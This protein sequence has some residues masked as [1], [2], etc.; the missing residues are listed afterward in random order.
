MPTMN[1]W[2][3]AGGLG[4]TDNTNWAPDWT[5]IAQQSNIFLL[6]SPS[7]EGISF[8]VVSNHNKA[9]EEK[10]FPTE[11]NPSSS[12]LNRSLNSTEAYSQFQKL[13][14][15]HSG[16]V[17]GAEGADP[18]KSNTFEELDARLMAMSGLPEDLAYE[19]Q[20]VGTTDIGM[21]KV[22]LDL[23]LNKIGKLPIFNMRDDLYLAKM[24]YASYDMQTRINA[25]QSCKV[26][27]LQFY[28]NPEIL[29]AM[30]SANR[31]LRKIY[32]QNRR[33]AL[34]EGK[35]FEEFL[36]EAR[37]NEAQT[38]AP[39]LPTEPLVAV[40]VKFEDQ[41]GNEIIGLPYRL[42]VRG[43]INLDEARIKT[44]MGANPGEFASGT[45]LF[46]SGG[47]MN[48]K[49]PRDENW[50]GQSLD[51]NKEWHYL[52]SYRITGEPNEII[53]PNGETFVEYP[54]PKGN[55]KI[56]VTTPEN[57]GNTLNWG[58]D[59]LK[60]YR[61]VSSM[62][63]NRD[64][65]TAKAEPLQQLFSH[66][67]QLTREKEYIRL[68]VT[69]PVFKEPLPMHLVE[70]PPN[71]GNV[72]SK[73]SLTENIDALPEHQKVQMT[74][75]V[76]RPESN[77]GW[78]KADK[79][80]PVE[81]T[82]YEDKFLQFDEFTSPAGRAAMRAG[83]IGANAVKGMKFLLKPLNNSWASAQNYTFVDT[84]MNGIMRVSM[85][86]GRYELVR[87]SDINPDGTSAYIESNE[88]YA[89]LFEQL[90]ASTRQAIVISTGT[91][92]HYGKSF[93][94]KEFP[95]ARL[96]VPAA[97]YYRDVDE[98]DSTP[99]GV[100][101]CKMIVRNDYSNNYTARLTNF[102]LETP[103]PPLKRGENANP[104]TIYGK[105]ALVHPKIEKGG[106]P[107]ADVSTSTTDAMFDTASVVMME[108][109]SIDISRIPE[110]E[111][112][113]EAQRDPTGV[114]TPSPMMPTLGNPI[115]YK[116]F[117]ISRDFFDT[118]I[119]PIPSNNAG[120]VYTKQAADVTYMFDMGK[121]ES[122][123]Y[124]TGVIEVMTYYPKN[125]NLRRKVKLPYDTVASELLSKTA[126][127]RDKT[128][129]VGMPKQGY[130][131]IDL[132]NW[133]NQQP[134]IFYLKMESG[135]ESAIM[136]GRWVVLTDFGEVNNPT[137]MSPEEAFENIIVRIDKFYGA[138]MTHYLLPDKPPRKLFKSDM[139]YEL[140]K[141][142]LKNG[143]Y[144]WPGFNWTNYWNRVESWLYGDDT[145]LPPADNSGNGADA[146]F[147]PPDALLPTG[148]G[149]MSASDYRRGMSGVKT[150]FDNVD[151]DVLVAPQPNNSD[152][153]DED[154]TLGMISW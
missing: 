94:M 46:E 15:E 109:S 43:A 137:V 33:N 23:N 90:P 32:V 18:N 115:E 88:P 128:F 139:S 66:S 55:V 98:D 34:A 143:L 102:K 64:A 101:G 60:T 52:Y 77:D 135:P 96:Q 40:R 63:P 25:L 48:R 37:T 87:V 36:E 111:R 132:L 93:A 35:S 100:V 58:N 105:L 119:G 68:S 76:M 22:R 41:N 38:V 61:A 107:L 44:N 85:P 146:P 113:L 28:I 53:L 118:S 152:D 54:W 57:V 29:S 127:A 86:V 49:I 16:L 70:L 69:I 72:V 125:G 5:V 92:E 71:S 45:K 26:D 103:F 153:D 21:P 91:E 142:S 131:T 51:P 31:Q 30:L 117:V 99:L 8:I 79:I 116:G 75:K 6:Q 80:E 151:E 154:N 3:Y 114:L 144:R 74:L 140:A 136:T 1:S 24:R 27:I 121:L 12:T 133:A 89:I 7:P 122:P 50:N 129:T 20:R 73:W 147:R 42:G 56:T 81:R 62:T 47:D 145:T 84:D 148:G 124:D 95:I 141:G 120:V 112:R 82:G 78:E 138:P 106:W 19:L 10:L 110:Y 149:T 126:V 67:L 134:E 65:N 130:S 39:M 9:N 83:T 108:D 150:T 59:R 2:T 4:A 104:D 13:L 14:I 11:S 123:F 17:S 97:Y